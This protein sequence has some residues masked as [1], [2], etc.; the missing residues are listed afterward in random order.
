MPW[1]AN[2]YPVAM[3]NLAPAVRLKAIEIA[4]AMLAAGR[5]EGQSIRVA[6]AVAKRQT[7]ARRSR[8]ASRLQA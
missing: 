8:P 2:H 6:I 7:G 5:P 3:K 4:N 1:S